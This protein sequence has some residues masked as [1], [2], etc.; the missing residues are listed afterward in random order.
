MGLRHINH[1]YNGENCCN[2]SMQEPATKTRKTSVRS[3]QREPIMFGFNCTMLYYVSLFEIAHAYKYQKH[4][5][6][7][8]RVIRIYNLPRLDEMCAPPKTETVW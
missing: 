2:K 4:M 1:I 5:I 8:V 6:I 3:F 7:F